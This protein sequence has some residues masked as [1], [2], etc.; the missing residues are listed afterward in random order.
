M[1]SCARDSSRN[2]N[3]W[4]TWWVAK[5]SAKSGL[6]AAVHVGE[7]PILHDS[8]S[9]RGHRVPPLSPNGKI[10]PRSLPEPVAG[11]RTVSDDLAPPMTE[12]EVM[13]ARIWS[14]ILG[15][16][17]VGVQDNFF[18]LGGHSMLAIR[19]FAKIEEAFGIR[20]PLA[21]LFR[22]A[23]VKELAEILR[24][25]E[26]SLS[27]DWIV[28]LQPDGKQ[29]PLFLVHSVSGNLLFWKPLISHL[30]P[31]QPCYGLHPRVPRRPLGGFL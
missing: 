10:D 21:A 23:T 1:Y 15:L 27:R 19:L 14:E 17:K 29:R 28:P 5:P 9:L 24:S 26:D 7:A 2:R 3:S 11:D 12:T 13:L 8:V 20:I 18:D 30:G 22:G 25:R 6:S 16:D 31:E 4:P